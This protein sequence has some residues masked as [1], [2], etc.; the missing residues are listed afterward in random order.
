MKRDALGTVRKLILIVS[1]L[2]GLSIM[3]GCAVVGPLLTMGGV[4]GIAPLQYASTAY[5]IGEFSYEY[6][7]NDKDPGDVIETKIGNFMSG[8]AFRIEQQTEEPMHSNTTMVAEASPQ[9]PESEI[10]ALTA[11]ARQKRIAKLLG[12]RH[13]Q[14]ERLEKRRMAFLKAQNK[15]TLSLRQTAMITRPDLINGAKDETTLRQFS[16]DTF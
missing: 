5:T 16:T 13:L 9:I 15:E 3:P 11:Q 10:P 12:R 2:F 7:V 6:A 4:A 8:D 1:T 14:M